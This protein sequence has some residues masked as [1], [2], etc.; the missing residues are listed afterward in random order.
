[1]VVVGEPSHRQ[2]FGLACLLSLCS[3]T[4]AQA[5]TGGSHILVG[6]ALAP[7]TGS[8]VVSFVVGV[9]SHTLLDAMPH[10]EFGPF[11]YPELRTGP[12]ADQIIRVMD[13]PIIPYG[14]RHPLYTAFRTPVGDILTQAI[15]GK[16]PV[17][18][19]LEQAEKTLRQVVAEAEKK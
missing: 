4:S 1:V 14:S 2:A 7:T 5:F 10:W 12:Y 15:Q 3:C 18:A 19:A 9:A 17:P 13:G 16:M 8:I 6:A 11:A